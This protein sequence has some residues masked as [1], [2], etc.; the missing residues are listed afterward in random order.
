MTHKEENYDDTVITGI[1]GAG[2]FGREVMPILDSPRNHPANGFGPSCC[3]FIETN[4][5][6]QQVDGYPIISEAK[7]LGQVT[8]RRFFNVAVAN[9][10]V[11]QRT[12]EKFIAHGIKP[13]LI[14][15]TLASVSKSSDVGEGAIL[16]GNTIIT[17][18]ASIGRFFHLNIFSYV[19][20]DCIIGD[21][22][23]FAP[24]VHCN[25][26]VIIEDHAFIG[27]GAIIRPGVTGRPLV[28]GTGAVV[29]MG[30]VVTR[31]VLPYTT[32]VGNPAKLLERQ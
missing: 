4:P 20:H 24:N 9:S 16:C 6:E 19:A 32:V 23:T 29:G 31:D 8:K 14:Q 25:G 15:S 26:N 1:F 28:I 18:N 2:G 30:A 27:T 22:V 11:R 13:I 12:V 21:F 5:S 10:S 3:V 7:F 17:S